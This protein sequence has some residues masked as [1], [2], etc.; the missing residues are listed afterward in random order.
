MVVSFPFIKDFHFPVLVL[1][2]CGLLYG[3]VLK[4]RGAER[5]VFGAW[6]GDRPLEGTGGLVGSEV[7][8]ARDDEGSGGAGE[9]TRTPRDERGFHNGQNSGGRRCSGVPGF[10]S[11]FAGLKVARLAPKWV[12]RTPRR[13]ALSRELFSNS[14]VTW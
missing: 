13:R 2:R 6:S 8:R 5:S 3:S 14:K 9:P 11:R 1:N 10:R 12:E 4:Y 7:E